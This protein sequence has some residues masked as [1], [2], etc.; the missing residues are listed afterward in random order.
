MKNLIHLLFSLLIAGMIPMLAQ[1]QSL[2]G[3]VTDENEVPLIGVTIALPSG[4]GGTVTDAD[5]NFSLEVGDAKTVDVSYIGFT[6]KTVEVGDKSRITIVIE[7]ETTRLSEVYVTARKTRE[8][9]QK[10][11]IAVSSFNLKALQSESI[12]I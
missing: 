3:T 4:T 8:D 6:K 9:L 12:A 7:P 2:S 10:V 5:G 11:P 1:S